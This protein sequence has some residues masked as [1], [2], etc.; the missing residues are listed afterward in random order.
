MRDVVFHLADGQMRSCFEGFFERDQ[1]HLSL[2]CGPFTVDTNQDLFHDPLSKDPELFYK[3]HLNL[4]PF[5]ET[6]EHAVI[7]LD[8]QWDQSDKTR[9]E[10]EEHITAKMLSVGWNRDRFEVICIEPEL[11]VWL[12]QNNNNFLD[13]FRYCDGP[14]ELRNRLAV[15]NVWPHEHAKPLN[16]KHA[17]GHALSIGKSVSR[18]VLFKKIC[19]RITVRS[20]QDQSFV[21]LMSTLQRWYPQEGL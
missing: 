3:A 5:F 8:W 11:E 4:M 6:H 19:S 20:C 10:I 2:G 12:F 18:S 1:Y 14:R 9:T 16:P 13:H 21:K 15:D 7:V 17:I